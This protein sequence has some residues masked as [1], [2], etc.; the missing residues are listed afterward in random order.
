LK[1]AFMEKWLLL[2]SKVDAFNQR[3][4]L[5]VFGAAALLT[6]TVMHMLLLDSLETSKKRLLTEISADQTLALELQQQVDL[7]KNK[8]PIDPDAQNK[9]RIAELQTQLQAL[10]SAQSQL[11]VSLISP[12]KMPE[13]LRDLLSKNGKL[14]LIALNTLPTQNLIEPLPA[15]TASNP[16]QQA[17]NPIA[18]NQVTT[19]ENTLFKHGVEITVEGRYLDLLEYV[20]AIENMHWHL[21]WNSAELTVNSYPNN[22][23]K[24]TVYTLSLD[25]TWLSI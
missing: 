11:N 8:P 3:E 4:R 10:Q 14:K 18:P 22:Q 7:Y 6:Y 25:K 13:L 15:P 2:S 20:A 23:L 16:T 19:Q 1:A 5:M 12:D 17:P 24:L 21:L 9:Q